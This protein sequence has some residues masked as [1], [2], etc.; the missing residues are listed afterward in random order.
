M[1]NYADASPTVT[2]CVFRGNDN[3]GINNLD[4]DMTLTN[5]I[6]C[7]NTPPQVDS[8]WIDGGGNLIADECPPC[9]DADT[10]GSG[11]V[12]VLD[13][14]NVVLDWDTDGSANGGDVDGSGI[15]D[16]TDL[17]EVILAWGPCG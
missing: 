11:I 13:L 14:V 6:V 3:N 16:V 17:T 2:D 9:L 4:G 12:D 7:G 10:D 1:Y 8:Y 5:T 15:V